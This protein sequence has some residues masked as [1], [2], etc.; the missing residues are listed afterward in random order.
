MLS[1]DFNTSLVVLVPYLPLFVCTDLPILLYGRSPLSRF[2]HS[3]LRITY[4]LPQ[5]SPLPGLG[6]L[7][8]SCLSGHSKWPP[9]QY[10]P[11]LLSLIA[12]QR[13]QLSPYSWRLY[14]LWRW[15]PEDWVWVA[16][17]GQ[18][19]LFMMPREECNQHCY[20]DVM[21][22]NHSIVQPGKVSL[23]MEDWF[24][25]LAGNP[26]CLTGSKAHSTREK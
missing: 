10:R 18:K 3:P 24:S 17:R 16:A 6:N 2:P 22:R 7:H 15:D 4:I 26:G 8:L 1:G 14:I 25:Y 5:S 21:P 23:M 11:L 13:L 12:S 9:E 19:I 20:P